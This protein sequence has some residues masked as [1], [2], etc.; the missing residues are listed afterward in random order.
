MS[1]SEQ[2]A[3]TAI[4]AAKQAAKAKPR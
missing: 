1:N 2:E 4:V 3:V